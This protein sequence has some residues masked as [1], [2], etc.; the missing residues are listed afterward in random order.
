MWLASK[1]ATY[2]L[3]AGFSYTLLRSWKF[4]VFS[5]LNISFISYDCRIWGGHKTLIKKWHIP[6]VANFVLAG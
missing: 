2:P 6:A 1:A 4:M 3:S 5:S